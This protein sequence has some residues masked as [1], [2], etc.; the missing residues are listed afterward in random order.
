MVWA[1]PDGDNLLAYIARVSNPQNQGKV[2]TAPR[3]IRYMVK[4]RH[5][6]PFEM[7]DACLEIN[8]TRDIGRQI[9]RHRSFVFQEFSQRYASA[10]DLP[11]PNLREARMQHP[12][13][14]Q[15]SVPCT[16]EVLWDEWDRRQEQVVRSSM[17]AYSWAIQNG[18]S[19]EVARAVLPEGL[20]PTRMYMKGSL[21]SW[22]HFYQARTYE[23]AQLEVQQVAAAVGQVLLETF[24]VTW[25]AMLEF[26]DA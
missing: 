1:T 23:G 19:K 18:I 13:N 21:R 9:L 24:P 25:A 2:E 16:D 5:W 22:F 12:T 10:L 26:K 14:R 6:S 20:T 7:V 4:H 15:A 3:L 17:G 8:T 11:P